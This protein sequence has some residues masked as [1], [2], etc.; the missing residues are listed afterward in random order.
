MKFVIKETHIY[1]RLVYNSLNPDHCMCSTN[2]SLFSQTNLWHYDPWFHVLCTTQ[3]RCLQSVS[4][5]TLTLLSIS[6]RILLS[7]TTNSGHTM[8]IWCYKSESE[9]ILASLSFQRSSTGHSR[10]GV[11]PQI[12]FEKN[13]TPNTPMLQEEPIMR[14]RKMS[15]RRLKFFQLWP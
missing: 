9:A 10:I 7:V 2:Q 13:V 3:K 15:N 6:K 1:M 12:T 11:T 4:D 5:C 8:T 14:T